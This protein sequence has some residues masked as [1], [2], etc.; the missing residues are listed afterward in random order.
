MKK[1]LDN[2][3]KTNI[4][5]LPAVRSLTAIINIQTELEMLYYL[6]LAHYLIC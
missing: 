6:V 3:S 1:R 4:I 2:I 5:A